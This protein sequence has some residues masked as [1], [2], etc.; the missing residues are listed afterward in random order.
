MV[1]RK[2]VKRRVSR[3]V[4]DVFISYAHEDS[5]RLAN[6]LVKALEREGFEVWYDRS[7]LEPGSSLR[8]SI[9]RGIARARLSIVIISPAFLR[10]GWPLLELDALVGLATPKRRDTVWPLL[11]NVT[12]EALRRRMPMVGS[13]VCI[14]YRGDISEIVDKVHRKL[15]PDARRRRGVELRVSVAIVR[16]KDGKFL[17]VKRRRSEGPLGWQFP[18]GAVKRWEADRDAATRE[19]KTETGVH[20]RPRKKLGERVHP[21]TRTRLTYWLCTATRSRARLVDDKE[22]EDVRWVEGEEAQR[23]ITS[24]LYQPVR[25]LL[26]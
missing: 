6:S 18:A 7:S 26:N 9:E 21:D 3:E 24:D 22:N 15:R 4:P 16:R 23:L 17:L 25:S 13:I 10:R 5:A 2:A 8:A 20:C 19:V 11:R 12:P 14:K 1:L